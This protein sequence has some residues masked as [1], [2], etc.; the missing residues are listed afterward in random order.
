MQLPQ[1]TLVCVVINDFLTTPVRG[2]GVGVL[3]SQGVLARVQ[4]CRL[5]GFGCTLRHVLPW[6]LTFASPLPLEHTMLKVNPALKRVQFCKH[7]I[8]KLLLPLQ[9]GAR[10]GKLV[11]WSGDNHPRGTNPALPGGWWWWRP[12]LSLL[13]VIGLPCY[14]SGASTWPLKNSS[15]KTRHLG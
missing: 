5:G 1:K 6:P 4:E 9:Q 7:K 11:F 14:S 3:Q 10:E 15:W 13:W 8:S 2:L 12:V